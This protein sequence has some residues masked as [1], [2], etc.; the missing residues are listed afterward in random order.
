MVMLLAA[1]G[2]LL[3]YST[4]CMLSTQGVSGDT[5]SAVGGMAAMVMDCPV[6]KCT[7]AQLPVPASAERLALTPNA[8]EIILLAVLLGLVAYAAVSASRRQRYAPSA[9]WV[10][11]PPGLR[12][13]RLRI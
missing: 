11:R 3:A 9:L 4:G 8:P 5:H 12:F 1:V 2:W 13:Y 6:A 10:T 7:Q